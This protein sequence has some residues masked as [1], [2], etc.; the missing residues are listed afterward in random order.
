MIDAT[1][2]SRGGEAEQGQQKISSIAKVVA[3][4]VVV[5]AVAV[6]GF[7]SAAAGRSHNAAARARTQLVATSASAEA[8]SAPSSS[9]LRVPLLAQ[10]NASPLASNPSSHTTKNEGQQEPSN[11]SPSGSTQPHHVE[12]SSSASPGTSTAVLAD[13]RVILNLANEEDLKKLR[14][15]GPAKA[16][17]I[18]ALRERMG[19]RFKSIQDLLRVKGLGRKMLERLKPQ[20]LLDP[21]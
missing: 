1:A 16:K 6:F 21:P 13:G 10:S 19:G 7:Q 14:G 5:G 15:V 20:L 8:V 2:T 12:S 4:L 18:L 11:V 17:A 3:A 9:Q